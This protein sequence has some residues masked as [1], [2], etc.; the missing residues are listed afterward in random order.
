[1][2]HPLDCPAWSALTSRQAALCLGG[3]HARRFREDIGPFAGTRDTSPEAVAALAALAYADDDMSLLE[4]APP[5]PPP[6]IQ[7]KLSALGVQMTTKGFTAGGRF[8]IEPLSDA[9][10]PEMIALATL[11]KPGPFRAATHALGRF[12][13]IRDNGRLVAMAGERMQM[14]GF[15]EISAVCTHPDYRGRGYGAALMR[16]VGDRI[17]S[18]GDTPFLHAYASNTAAIAL[19]KH[20]GFELRTEVTHAMWSKANG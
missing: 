17:L 20:L 10:A 12:V 1:M 11:T 15:V 18:E 14:P 6:G 2:A 19:Y 5:A 8:S 4:V 3:E 7:L 9:D 16:A 13:G